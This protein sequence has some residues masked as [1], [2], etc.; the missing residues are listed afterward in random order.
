MK[1]KKEIENFGCPICSGS[2]DVM[3]GDSINPRNGITLRC[4]GDCIEVEGH[5]K[6]EKEAFS[7]I[8]SKFCGKQQERDL[9]LASE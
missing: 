7:V 5:G 3:S 6:N 4:A 2:L 1:L 8:I 9:D